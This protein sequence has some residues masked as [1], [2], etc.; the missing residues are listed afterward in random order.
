MWEGL[1]FLFVVLEV[2][3][4]LAPLLDLRWLVDHQ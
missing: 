1:G 4:F 3:T 2:M